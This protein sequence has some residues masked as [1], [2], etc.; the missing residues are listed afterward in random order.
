MIG[1]AAG[2]T[3]LGLTLLILVAL[4]LVVVGAYFSWWRVIPAIVHWSNNPPWLWVVGWMGVFIAAW[5][6]V[7]I[8][9]GVWPIVASGLQTAAARAP[10]G[11]ALGDLES[12]EASLRGS[13]DPVDYAIYG[14]KALKAYYLQG[15]SQARLSFYI[16]VVAMLFGFAFLLG[17]LLVQ[18][19]DVSSVPYLRKDSNPSLNLVTVGGGLI[20]EFVAATFLWVYR[21]AIVQLTIYYK[22]QLLVHSALIAVAVSQSM[23]GQREAALLKIIDTMI[24][25]HWD[26][27]TATLALPRATER[28]PT[29]ASDA[30]SK[31][32]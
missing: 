11:K 24:T 17:G 32:A 9:M 20:I 18:V 29:A 8:G 21:A 4:S 23:G 25:P 16:G 1:R 13:V 26:D 5:A 12:F 30:P 7:F 27:T 22:R 31:S 10:L 15:L 28:H 6:P 2:R 3:R 19:L 14:R